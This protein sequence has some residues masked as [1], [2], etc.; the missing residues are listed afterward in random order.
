MNTNHGILTPLDTSGVWPNYILTDTRD[1][2]P[3]H[4]KMYGSW[5]RHLIEDAIKYIPEGSTIL[6]IGA[7]IGT[8]SVY[9]AQLHKRT[10][11]KPLTIHSFEPN[12]P[13]YYNLCANILINNS[14][15]VNTYRC[16]LSDASDY[17]KIL[18][19]YTL[20]GNIGATRLDNTKEYA[21][22]ETYKAKLDYLDRLFPDELI[23][24]IKIDVEGHEEK[25]LR[26][27]EQLILRSK[28][29]IYFESWNIPEYKEL[30]D[31]LFQYIRSLNYKIENVKEHDYRAV[32][33][34]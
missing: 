21:F 23:S 15:N 26:G 10:G 34:T 29:V 33:I 14:F 20:A 4:I 11:C 6:D 8:W 24:F 19:L 12:P 27:G 18:P 22:T 30:Q 31:S 5:E 17:N 3:D 2:I 7:N 1:C 32:P 28:P 9:L 13:T 16:A 25:V